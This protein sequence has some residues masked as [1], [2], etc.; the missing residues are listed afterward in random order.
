VA[1]VALLAGVA[2]AESSPPTYAT[3]ISRYEVEGK[4]VPFSYPNAV[5]VDPSGNIWVADSVTDR[6]VKFNAERR[7][8][9]QFGKEGSGEG[10]F[11]GIAGIA[12][13][14]SGDLY[15]VDVGN[16]RVQEF[17]PFG[18]HLRS[19]GSLG[20]GEGQ[21]IKPSAI[22]VD[23][24]GD[25]WVL[26]NFG[27]Q[28]QEF[29]P[30]GKYLSGF[31]SVGWGFSGTP[32]L[33]PTAMTFS[34][35]NL[36]VTEDAFERVDEV[37]PSGK[38]IASFGS[39]GFANEQ[40]YKRSGIATDPVTGNLYVTELGTFHLAFPSF[41]FEPTNIPVQEFSP[42][43]SFIT[44]VGS[45]GSGNGQ[46]VSPRDVAVAPSGKVYVADT[47]N[48]R[49]Q[50]WVPHVII[51]V[52]DYPI[53]ESTSHALIAKGITS[54]RI[55]MGRDSIATSDSYGFKNQT[56]IVGNTPDGTRLSEIEIA[57]WLPETVKQVEECTA[58]GVILDEVGNE[59]Y[60]KGGHAEPAKYA[61]MFMALDDELVS[62]DERSGVKLLF[63]AFGD[64]YTGS[65]WS[66]VGSKRGW[67]GDALTTQSGLRTAID[68]FTDHPYG[69]LKECEES[70]WG[71]GCV[72]VLHEEAKN[73]GVANLGF[74]ITE[75]G[76]MAPGSTGGHALVANSEADENQ[77]AREVYTELIATGYVRGIWWFGTYDAYPERTT[78]EKWGLF[79]GQTG[80]TERGVLGIVA[81]FG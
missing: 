54:D 47:G 63:N 67:I 21:F 37:S 8:L 71:P 80:L 75:F 62:K 7:F 35:G 78:N 14:A 45:H 3:S 46:F 33:S 9:R 31:G 42:S 10:Q 36:Y 15:V 25:V 68:G 55:E 23:S 20:T 32:L 17:G 29:S 19:F 81:S 61:E 40:F 64:Y 65:E 5:A 27:I 13:N 58:G 69:R 76:I 79:E 39:E 53:N 73:L 60:L 16:H 6:I 48:K 43:G 38:L 74:Y 59:M 1:G 11:E 18:E 50:E 56:C 49:V 22:A 72:S 51:G 41:L 66:Q 26:N 30:E 77:W 52:N 70:S 57:K 2:S 44:A 24:Q 28:V 4:E 12:T 34:G